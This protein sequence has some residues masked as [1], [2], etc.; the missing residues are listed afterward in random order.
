MRRVG[1]P[2]IGYHIY[3]YLYIWAF[4]LLALVHPKA[5]LAV[6]GRYQQKRDSTLRKAPQNAIWMHCASLGEFEQGRALLEMIRN[7]HPE[8][9]LVLSFYSPSGYE[10]RK[11]YQGVDTVLYLPFD[12][13]KNAK[14]WISVLKPRAAIFVKYEF[15]YHHIQAVLQAQI[16]IYF[17]AVSLAQ[18]HWLFHWAARPLKNLL[19]SNAIFFT[20]E[21]KTAHF[22]KSMEFTAYNSGDPRV[23]RVMS[24]IPNVE[25]KIRSY[26][27]NRKV[28]I[29]ASLHVSDLHVIT[30][31]LNPL[32]ALG[33]KRIIIVPHETDERTLNKFESAFRTHDPILLLSNLETTSNSEILMIDRVGILSSLYP[34]AQL[35]YVGGGFGKGI[36][37][38]LEPMAAGIPVIFGPKFKRFPEAVAMVR[39]KACLSIMNVQQFLDGLTYF[40]DQSQYT[41]AI[42]HIRRYLEENKGASR[43][44]LAYLQKEALFD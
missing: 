33:F 32:K 41:Q 27:S 17:I 21:Q 13:K 3:I 25:T 18:N 30:S 42:A 19:Q 5:K 10:T 7:T 23:D 37:N 20:Q 9:P 40:Q 8:I 31:V 1:A 24:I 16:P 34:Y 2:W 35:T 29:A 12:S 36:H 4:R 22:L 44:I 26:L 11:N 28:F 39:V 43:Q 38:T 14:E 6:T 15:W